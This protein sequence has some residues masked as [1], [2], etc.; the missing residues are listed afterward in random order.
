MTM[1][2][3]TISRAYSGSGCWRG[4]NAGAIQDLI[5]GQWF[6]QAALMYAELHCPSAFS[7]L[8]GASQPDEL[9]A[10]A[11]RLGLPALALTDRNG[12]T[13]RSRSRTPTAA[14][15][16]AI[17]G[18]EVTLSD[19]AHVCWLAE[20]RKGTRISVACSRKRTS[21]R[22]VSTRGCRSARSSAP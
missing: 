16:Q 4:E 19:G 6:A 20:S 11:H 12:S 18:A 8:D 14:R 21:V 2:A 9:L 17:T 15:L 5:T 7:F 10:E 13:A 3:Q 22:S 1:V